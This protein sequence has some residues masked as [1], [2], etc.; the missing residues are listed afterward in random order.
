MLV[1]H[2]AVVGAM[3]ARMAQEGLKK[4]QVG[5]QIDKNCLPCDSEKK[6]CCLNRALKLW[7]LQTWADGGDG[8]AVPPLELQ[9]QE[10]ARRHALPVFRK[11]EP[12]FGVGDMP[13]TPYGI[14]AQATTLA[15]FRQRRIDAGWV[16]PP[17]M[18]PPTKKPRV[19]CAAALESDTE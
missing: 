6:R 9:L 17:A 15:I 12:T 3:Q 8:K 14:E 18:P 1:Y 19:Q 11:R 10:L 16:P 5:A 13:S 2:T 4:A 7:R